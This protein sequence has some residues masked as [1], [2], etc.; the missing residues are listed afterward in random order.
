M[1]ESIAILSDI[2]AN[3][4]ALEAVLAD[5]DNQGIRQLLCLGDVVGYGAQPAG[6]IDRLQ[7][8]D[9][10]AILRGNH[11]AYAAAEAN[12]TNVSPETLQ[13]ICWTRAKLSPEHRAWLGALPF[14]WQG[15]G[16]EAVHASLP[17]PEAWEYVLEASA[18]A[19]HFSRQQQQICFIGHS[20]QPKMFVERD[21][22]ALDITNIES[23]RSDR[24]QVINVGSVGQPRDKDERA[25][26]LIYRRD[27]QDV[28]WRRV[29]YD[30]E[31]A[32]EAIISAGLPI[33]FAQRLAMGK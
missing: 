20:H 10:L 11:D 21:Q 3:Q 4:P 30:I 15:H 9:F 25:C 14:T 8:R 28:W 32:Q 13:G 29:P 26:Y 23:I 19:R 12:P 33:K 1:S 17:H 16:A 2:H 31:K 24:K 5:I 18:A 6:C 27:R 7:S 22:L